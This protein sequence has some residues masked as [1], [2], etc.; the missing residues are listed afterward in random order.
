MTLKREIAALFSAL[1][2]T[3][4]GMSDEEFAMLLRREGKLQFAPNGRQRQGKAKGLENSPDIKK[5]AERLLTVTTREA[6]QEILTSSPKSG[7]KIYL[8]KVARML[9]VHVTKQD[10]IDRIAEKLVESVVGSKIRSDAIRTLP[11]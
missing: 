6:A 1:V 8:T 7:R 9:G 4:N 5:V 10:N 2:D 3:L 11:L